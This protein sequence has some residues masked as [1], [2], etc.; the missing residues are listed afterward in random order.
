M[1]IQCIMTRHDKETNTQL[2]VLGRRLKKTRC[3]C[4]SSPTASEAREVPLEYQHLSAT[5]ATTVVLVP[6]VD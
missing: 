6:Y 5:V 3:G 4:R 1:L 2:P